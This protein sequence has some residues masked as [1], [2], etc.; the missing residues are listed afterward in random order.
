MN[1]LRYAV[2]QLRKSPGFTF[3]AVLTLA[4]GIGANTAI[5]SVVNAVLLSPLPYPDPDRMVQL[6]LASPAWAPGQNANTAS[7]PEFMIFREQGAVL[8]NV[9]A[10]DSG[11]SINLTGFE[12]AEQIRAIHVSSEYFALF[13]VCVQ[14]GRAFS[15]QEDRPGGPHLALIS[16]G[17]WHRRFAKDSSL[18]GRTL[19]LAGET[20]SAVGGSPGRERAVG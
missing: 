16:D 1:T 9:A 8:E 4:L 2:R 11:R 6:M 15:A 10:Y 5:F 17:L 7:V 19:I 18:V 3:V 12:R 13:G 14:V 20:P